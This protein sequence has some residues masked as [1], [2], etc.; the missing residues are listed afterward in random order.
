L[1]AFGNR[2]FTKEIVNIDNEGRKTHYLKN[3]VGQYVD[4]QSRRI[5]QNFQIKGF[6]GKSSPIQQY[7][8]PLAD[9]KYHAEA[10]A[11]DYGKVPLANNYLDLNAA[12]QAYSDVYDRIR[13]S[14]QIGQDE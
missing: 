10:V 14:N 1:D 7:L 4:P 3:D 2:D 9:Q 11:V 13:D 5:L 8:D 12:D 6:K